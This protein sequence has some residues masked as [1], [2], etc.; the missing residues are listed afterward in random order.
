MAIT[1]DLQLVCQQNSH[2][3]QWGI[4]PHGFCV[5]PMYAVF[6]FSVTGKIEFSV[7]DYTFLIELLGFFEKLILL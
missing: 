6:L 7:M 5:H 4:W 3:N 1:E 2:L